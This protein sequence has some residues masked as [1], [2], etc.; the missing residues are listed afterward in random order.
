MILLKGELEFRKSADY[1][2]NNMQNLSK[3]T[4]E[5]FQSLRDLSSRQLLLGLCKLGSAEQ[6]RYQL[7]PRKSSTDNYLQYF[8]HKCFV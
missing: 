2:T 7:K 6:N 1:C 8:L 4:I 3:V 5:L